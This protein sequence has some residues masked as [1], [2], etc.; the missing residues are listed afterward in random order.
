M[1][2]MCLSLDELHALP[3][4]QCHIARP[5]IAGIPLLLLVRRKG[6]M[7]QPLMLDPM[8]RCPLADWGHLGSIIL[9]NLGFI[10]NMSFVPHE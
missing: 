10:S 8:L 9:L 7:C 4:A 5:L 1:M 2:M 3:H 6:T